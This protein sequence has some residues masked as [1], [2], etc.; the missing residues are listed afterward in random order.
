M[1][2]LGFSTF[3]N[4]TQNRASRAEFQLI[5][6]PSVSFVLSPLGLPASTFSTRTREVQHLE[7]AIKAAYLSLDAEL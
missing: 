3:A 2:C 5:P 4:P 7:A 6:R 1:I